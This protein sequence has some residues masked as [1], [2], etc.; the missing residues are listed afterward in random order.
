MAGAKDKNLASLY[1]RM[2][3][4]DV[5]EEEE[6]KEECE[7]GSSVEVLLLSCCLQHKYQINV[8]G[9]VAAYRLP[10][11]LVGDSVVC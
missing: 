9:T 5:W 2:V 3:R 1:L 4:F 6:N 8:D 10:Y 7:K 11:L